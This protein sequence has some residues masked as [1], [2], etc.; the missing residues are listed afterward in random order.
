MAVHSIFAITQFLRVSV[1]DGNVV[2]QH[3]G[4]ELGFLHSIHFKIIM[5]F[6]SRDAKFK[7]LESHG[8][9]L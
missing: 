3:S 5:V 2:V 4:I 6:K 7:R 1:L 9:G 8:G